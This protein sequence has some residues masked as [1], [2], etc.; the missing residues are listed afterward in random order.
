MG[1]TIMRYLSLFL[2]VLITSVIFLM[3]A[4]I[5]RIPKL[6][7]DPATKKVTL[8]MMVAVSIAFSIFV[9]ARPNEHFIS[10]IIGS[11][12]AAVYLL[13]VFITTYYSWPK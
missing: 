8:L 13:V 12:V 2:L 10:W 5:S 7:W 6:S 1:V 3:P 11:V 9:I 4:W